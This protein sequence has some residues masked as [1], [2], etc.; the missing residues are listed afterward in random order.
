MKTLKLFDYFLEF[1]FDEETLNKRIE[2]SWWGR[3]LGHVAN[4]DI[5]KITS[6]D[7]IHKEYNQ[8]KKEKFFFKISDEYKALFF[9]LGIESIESFLFPDP[10]HDQSF[11][12]F[13]LFLVS[14]NIG[15]GFFVIDRKELRIVKSRFNYDSLIDYIKSVEV[16]TEYLLKK[17][18]DMNNYAFE[19][20]K[21]GYVPAFNE[22]AQ[23]KLEEL[24]LH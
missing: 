3:N 11:L 1:P 13:D 18:I 24:K 23:L 14:K 15:D 20:Y 9:E 16:N 22:L 6:K 7:D 4:G 12:E 17:T 21:E 8:L 2:S 10:F 19:E 5:K